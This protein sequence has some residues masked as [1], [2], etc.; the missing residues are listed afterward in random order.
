MI[1]R[2]KILEEISQKLEPI[3]SQRSH[4]NS[5]VQNYADNFLDDFNQDTTYVVSE[6]MGKE[7]YDFP[8]EEK[9]K[10]IEEVLKC[11]KDNVDTPNLNPASGGHFGD[12]FCLGEGHQFSCR[13]GFHDGRHGTLGRLPDLPLCRDRHRARADTRG[14]I[15]HGRTG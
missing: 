12:R 7:I 14:H 11:L 8:I 5:T 13:V 6:T 2:I 9:G 15:P 3:G 10:P 1:K 4:W